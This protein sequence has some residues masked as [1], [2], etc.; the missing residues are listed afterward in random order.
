MLRI[1]SHSSNGDTGS[2]GVKIRPELDRVCVLAW[3]HTITFVY[4]T[5]DEAHNESIGL[6]TRF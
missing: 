6:K 5:D 1:A 2:N 3:T 4:T